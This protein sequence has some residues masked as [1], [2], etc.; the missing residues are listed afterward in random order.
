MDGIEIIEGDITE[1]AVEAIVNAANNQLILGS[2]VAGAIK[3]K[4]GPAIQAECVRIGPI[5]IGEAAITTGGNLKAKWVIHAASMGLGIPATSESLKAS[6]IASMEIAR[7]RKLSSIAFPALGTGVAGFSFVEC[8]EIMIGAV[9]RFLDANEYPR[10]VIFCLWGE[11][12]FG[13]FK[14]VLGSW[15]ER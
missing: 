3:R 4:G 7:E 10:R 6:T 9:K 1:Q 12:A 2:G 11:G 5:E 8:A 14:E 15:S 13:V